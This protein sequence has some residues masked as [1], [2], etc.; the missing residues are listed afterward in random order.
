MERQT[1]SHRFFVWND[2]L[3]PA[4]SARFDLYPFN[5]GT[6]ANIQ[7][8]VTDVLVAIEAEASQ[9]QLNSL[10]ATLPMQSRGQRRQGCT[11]EAALRIRTLPRT[12]PAFAVPNDV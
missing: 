6:V 7:K 11:E 1:V 12:G 8:L 5:I 3:T 4:N 9:K 10:R 2:V